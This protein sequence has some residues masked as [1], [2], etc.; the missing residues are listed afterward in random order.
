M[1]EHQQQKQLQPQQN[2]QHPYGGETTTTITTTKFVSRV[3]SIPI[4]QDS[5]STFQAMANK[6]KFGKFAISTMNCTLYNVVNKT[7]STYPTIYEQ[8]IQ[9]H[10]ER[11]DELGCRSLDLLQN[12]FPVVN[13][14]TPVLYEKVKHAPPVVVDTIKVKLDSS[15]KQPAIQVVK[16]ANDRFGHVV[17]NLEAVLDHYLPTTQATVDTHTTVNHTKDRDDDD[18]NSDE[19]HQQAAKEDRQKTDVNQL[20][21]AYSLFNSTKSRLARQV[22]D[23]MDELFNRVMESSV[24]IQK[25]TES[26]HQ[27][28]ESLIS[29]LQQQQQPVLTT[30]TDQWLAV[31]KTSQKRISNMSEQLSTQ[32]QTLITSFTKLQLVAVEKT[33]AAVPDS[34]KIRITSLITTVQE[35]LELVRTQYHN[36]EAMST[37]EDEKSNHSNAA[38]VHLLKNTVQ[39]INEQILPLLKAA[40]SQLN[41]YA[42]IA[43]SHE[44]KLLP[45]GLSQQ[46]QQRQQATA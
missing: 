26:V 39:A 19:K 29:Y 31:Q 8:Y 21:R 10:I 32:L 37:T 46:Q 24:L 11:A 30:V 44:F 16:E 40:Q 5:V 4:V 3:T 28:Q 22:S 18:N 6:T 35:R 7:T 36:T 2:N 17:D 1:K 33:T 14:P 41:H 34:V 27:L 23:Q 43:G 20:Y 25:I 45:F 15:I 9:P 42:D 13:Q 12:K 38:I